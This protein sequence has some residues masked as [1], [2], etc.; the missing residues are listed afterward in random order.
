MTILSTDVDLFSEVAKLPSEV[1]TIIVDHL[2][3]CI[4]PELLHFLPIR[5]KSHLQ[6]YQ[7]YTLPKMFKDTRVVTSYLLDIPVRL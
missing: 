4:L 3:K 1:I 6:F 7:M 5:R 2:P